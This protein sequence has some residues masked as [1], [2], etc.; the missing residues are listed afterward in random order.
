MNKLYIETY[1]CQMNVADSEVVVSILRNEGFIYTND[2]NNA[3]VILVNTCSIRENAEQR[4]W[5]R[6]DVFRLIKKKKPS[7]IIGVIG[8]MAERLKTKLLED[9]KLVDLVVGPDAYRDLPYLIKQTESGQHAIN[10]LLSREETY[11][12]I[13]PVRYDT[14]GVSAFVSIMR[15][16]DNVCAYCVVPFTRGRERSR[17]PE[18]I[19]NEINELFNNNYKEVTLLG[20]NVDKY[21]WEQE[22]NSKMNFAR[23]L[24]LVAT[25]FPLLRIRFSTSYPQ[26]MTDEVLTVMARFKNICKSI[27]L[28]IQSGSTRI[29][30]LMKRG[31]TREWY[32]NRIE[33]IRKILPDC[34]I[35]TDIITGFCSETDKD[36]QNTLTLLEWAK[37]DFAYMFKYSVRHNT[38]AERMYSDDVPDEIKTQRLN[39]IMELQHKV[40]EECKKA[41]IGKTFEVLIEGISKK[42][43]KEFYGRNSQNKVIVFPKG[44]SKIGD[45]VNIKVHR[46]TSATLIGKIISTDF[47]IS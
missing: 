10:V 1:G 6:L 32:M 2:I 23:L 12:D 30:E 4:V 28:P 40:S 7:T 47:E 20:Q 34:A 22:G 21:N 33:A 3:D 45:Y 16:C 5:G 37:F 39:E 8:C 41:D 25:K 35:T 19:L 18:T 17:N 26:D 31:Y 15:G 43:E 36:H 29:L 11:A 42:S 24:Y 14:N 46:A 27:H 13:S 9:E 38:F 44:D